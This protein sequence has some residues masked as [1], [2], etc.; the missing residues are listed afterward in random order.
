MKKRVLDVGNCM[1]DFTSIKNLFGQFDCDVDQAH[2]LQDTLTALRGGG[3]ALVTV[4]RKLDQDYSDGI[5]IIKAIKADP[6]LAEVPVMLVTNFPEHQDEAEAVGALRGFGKLE[7][8]SP[9]TVARLKAA[10]G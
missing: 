2:G 10:L 9:E 7:F 4:N 1:P 3:Y 5:E 8:D 6:A